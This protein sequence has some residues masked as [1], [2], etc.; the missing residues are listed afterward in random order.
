M[1]DS[2][3]TPEQREDMSVKFSADQLLVIINDVLDFSRVEG[4]KFT[5]DLAEFNLHQTLGS[6]LKELEPG[7]RQKGLDF[8]WDVTAEVPER[9]VG[10]ASRL[11]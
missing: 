9:I 3:L 7:A 10:D 5:L 2:E 11:Q 4:A 8:A 1:L 6:A